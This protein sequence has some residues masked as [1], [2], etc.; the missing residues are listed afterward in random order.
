MSKDLSNSP[1][2]G[3]YNIPGKIG[4]DGPKQSIHLR[5]DSA[6]YHRG[7]PGPGQYDMKNPTLKTSPSFVMGDRVPKA[8]LNSSIS[9]P[10]PGTYD[11]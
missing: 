7:K 1:G 2:V 11:Q 4:N 3:S 8:E 5:I 9:N 10:G 6:D